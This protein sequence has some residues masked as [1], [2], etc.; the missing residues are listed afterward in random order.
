MVSR[1]TVRTNAIIWSILGLV[2]AL[3]IH[4]IVLSS[5]RYNWIKDRPDRQDAGYRIELVTDAY[6]L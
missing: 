5:D 3:L 6:M 4:F 2:V 1:S